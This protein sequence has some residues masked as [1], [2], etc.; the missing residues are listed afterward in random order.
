VASL[1]QMAAR[2]LTLGGFAGAPGLAAWQIS[3]LAGPKPL[4]GPA[5]DLKQ[6]ITI[7]TTAPSQYAALA[8]LAEHAAKEKDKP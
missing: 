4:L 8:A 6:A 5:R 3:W 2:T 1:P 7:C